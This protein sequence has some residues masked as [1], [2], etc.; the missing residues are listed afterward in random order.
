LDNWYKDKEGNIPLQPLI[1]Y[2]VMTVAEVAI[3]VRLNFVRDPDAAAT[4]RV[5]LML[6]PSQAAQLAEDL[7]QTLDV[8]GQA[9]SQRKN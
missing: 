5:Q 7:V 4:G 8:L 1:G 3:G 2:G 9:P 6:T